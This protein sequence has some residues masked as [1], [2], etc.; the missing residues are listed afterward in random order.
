MVAGR[1]AHL[2]AV[3]G[4]INA[5]V[6]DAAAEITVGNDL[7]IVATGIGNTNQLDVTGSSG[8]GTLD[9]TTTDGDVDVEEVTASQFDTVNVTI[10]D[11]GVATMV[12]VAFFGGVDVVDLADDGTTL[13]F[14]GSGVDTDTAGINVDITTTGLNA[15]VGDGEVKTGTGDFTLTTTGGSIAAAAATASNGVAEASGAT[16]TLNVTGATNDVGTSADPF[17]VNATTLGASSGRDI[18]ITDVAGGFFVADGGITATNDAVLTSTDVGTPAAAVIDGAAAGALNGTAE[19]SVGNDLT[20]TGFGIGSVNGLEVTGTSGTGTLFV[21]GTDGDMNVQEVTAAQFDLIDLTIND[22]NAATTYDF[23][24]FGA[25]DTIHLNDDGTTLWFLATPPAA[26]DGIQMTDLDVTMRV[27][28]LDVVVGPGG[29]TMP[30][31]VFT[32]TTDGML[33]LPAL[34][35][36]PGARMG[37]LVATANRMLLNGSIYTTGNLTLTT[38]SSTGTVPLDRASIWSPGLAGGLILDTLADFSMA[39]GDKFTVLS[40]LTINGTNITVGD[41]TVYGDLDVNAGTAIF[42]HYRAAG[43]V[44]NYFGGTDNDDGVD[45]VSFGV[46]DFNQVPTMIGTPGIAATFANLSGIPANNNL[47]V[48]IFRN[49]PNLALNFY[50]SGGVFL[51]LT[52]KGT[53]NQDVSSTIAGAMPKQSVDVS[54]DVAISAALLDALRSLG[55]FARD[56]TPEEMLAYLEGRALYD[57]LVAPGGDAAPS[58]YEVAKSRLPSDAASRA[59]EAYKAIFWTEVTDEETGETRAEYLAPEIKSAFE[60]ALADYMKANGIADPA[61]V[62]GAAFREFINTSAAHANAGEL[63]DKIG[64]LFAQIANLG[65]TPV[66]LGISKSVLLRDIAPK[67]LNTVQ[68]DA[69][70]SG[71]GQM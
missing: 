30:G 6:L 16:V 65:L 32:I 19:I 29:L 64:D 28:G 31:R 57:D 68:M 44:L 20:L 62:D 18:F 14:T 4:T 58:D 12:D 38:T 43:S 34:G 70:I 8:T 11:A 63:A 48:F 66:E 40:D 67:G 26:P 35:N 56:L 5:A 36:P 13:T 55:I 25:G 61:A 33:T 7:T 45:I 15:S 42:I 22:A 9:L 27:T 49:Y 71:G 17:E 10:N 3:G 51:D 39:A 52:S 50:T 24:F 54:T 47:D 21:T 59:A 53:S 1:D 60:Q 2:T 41:L 23:D 69:M 46:L 37:G